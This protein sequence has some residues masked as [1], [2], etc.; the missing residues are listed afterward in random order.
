M[1]HRF[2][3]AEKL[4]KQVGNFNKITDT[5]RLETMFEF[6]EDNFSNLDYT[7]MSLAQQ[8][9]IFEFAKILFKSDCYALL[10][11]IMRYNLVKYLVWVKLQIDDHEGEIILLNDPAYDMYAYPDIDLC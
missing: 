7:Q 3:N 11:Q 9:Q 4:R 8:E 6:M 10:P 1:R 5:G 2:F